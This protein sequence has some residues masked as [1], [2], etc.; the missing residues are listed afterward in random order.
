[1]SVLTPADPTKSTKPTRTARAGKALGAALGVDLESLQREHGIDPAAPYVEPSDCQV[2]N[3]TCEAAEVLW[4]HVPYLCDEHRPVAIRA[5]AAAHLREVLPMEHHPA[6]MLLPQLA[7]WSPLS[8]RGV[9]LYGKT[10]RR[11]SYQLACLA[12][13]AWVALAAEGAGRPTIA[14]RNV[15]TMIAD[16]Q[17]TF[18]TNK[19][20]DTTALKSADVLVLDDIGIEQPG[21]FVVNRL[22]TIVNHRAEAK[23]PTLLSSNRTLAEL[24]DRLAPQIASRIAGSCD[25]HE[26]GGLD[27]RL[28]DPDKRDKLAAGGEAA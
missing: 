8:R 6:K 28:V 14:W 7:Y 1:M 17:E 11:K 21:E 4:N 22:Y 13:R 23:L 2:C 18:G 26:L 16:I 27:F 19:P 24:H 15:P 3:G 20:Y 5:H 12:R 25:Q 9:F 10:G